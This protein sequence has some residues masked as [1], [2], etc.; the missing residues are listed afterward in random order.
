MRVTVRTYRVEKRETRVAL[1]FYSHTKIWG[2]IRII[3]HQVIGMKIEIPLT[4][5]PFRSDA[6]DSPTRRK[7]PN[8]TPLRTDTYIGG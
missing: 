2:I 6:S 8:G 3:V 4:P 1:N 5:L 7:T